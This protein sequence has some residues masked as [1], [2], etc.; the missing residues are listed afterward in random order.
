MDSRSRGIFI[1]L[2]VGYAVITYIRKSV[3]FISPVVMQSE[4][5]S[6]SELG[7]ILSSQT[8]GYSVGKLLGGVMV[9]M[10]SPSRIFLAV[11]IL[12]AVS[13]VAFTVFDTVAMFALCWFV[14]GFSQGPSWPACAVLIKRW[15]P[16]EKFGT[17]WSMLSTSMN[18]SG[19]AGPII[20]AF[21]L[22]TYSWRFTLNLAGSCAVAAAG[23]AFFVLADSPSHQIPPLQRTNTNKTKK[24]GIEW[25]SGVWDILTQPVFV[26]TCINYLLVSL[27]RGAG[28]D[29]GHLYLIQEK[30]HSHFTGSSFTSSQELGGI[31]GSLAA[32]YISD[33][34]IAKKCDYYNPRLLVIF[35][36]TVAQSASIFL[37]IS[38]ISSNSSSLLIST[39][40]FC[41]GFGV[42][43][44]IAM[45]GVVAMESTIDRLAGTAHSIVAL[46]ANVG[47]MLSGY[48]LSVV[49]RHY[50]WH[51]AFFLVQG[52]TV[53]TTVIA[54][55]S[56]HCSA[57]RMPVKQHRS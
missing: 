8:L 55:L 39:V 28:N 9:D 26:A 21:L 33:F 44:C 30:H 43:G 3:S 18:V 10:Y 52:I 40:G 56:A 36:C 54:L 29:W 17:W 41:L 1:S 23:M 37:F 25:R 46:A 4:G 7:M 2:Y 53:L 15:F 48:P 16:P 32:G 49:A 51:T 34:L 38:S 31:V 50:S 11:L 47:V 6:K 42:Y 13:V 45:F 14:N 27:V 57:R 35:F 19:T 20:S 12:A 22:T 24:S 5:L